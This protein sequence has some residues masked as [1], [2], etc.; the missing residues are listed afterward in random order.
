MEIK[1]CIIKWRLGQK[2]TKK[3]IKGFLEANKNENT[4]KQNLWGTLKT[5][6]RGNL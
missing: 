6:P 3:Q 4:I 5:V 2:E 1:Q